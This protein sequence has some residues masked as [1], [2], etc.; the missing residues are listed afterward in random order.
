MVNGELE[1][2]LK[3]LAPTTRG[4]RMELDRAAVPALDG[5]LSAFTSRGPA[6]DGGLK[7][8]LSAP[9]DGVFTAA[10]GQGTRGLRLSGTSLAAPHAAGAAALVWHAARE[11]GWQLSARDVAALLVTGADPAAVRQSAARPETPPITRTG[12][13]ALDVLAAASSRTVVRAGPLASLGLG[14]RALVEALT[15]ERAVTVTNLDSVLRTYQ[16]EAEHRLPGADAGGLKVTAAPA[17]LEL[18][19][20]ETAEVRVRF[21][22]RPESLPEWPMAGGRHVGDGDALTEAE[23]GGWLVVRDDTSAAAPVTQRVPFHLLARRASSV[24]ATWEPG[25]E[26]PEPVQLTNASAHPGTAEAF[27]LGTVDPLHRHLPGPVDLT[28]VGVRA[29]PDGQGNTVLEFLLHAREPYGHPLETFSQ[30]EMDTNMDGVPDYIAYTVDEAGMIAASDRNGRVKVAVEPPGGSPFGTPT[31]RFYAGCDLFSRWLILPLLA[32][33]TGLTPSRLAFQYRVTRRS[34]VDRAAD[35]RWAVDQA[36]G[37]GGWLSFDAR[38]ALPWPAPATARVDGM[39]TAQIE[40][41]GSASLDADLLVLFPDNPPGA[42]DAVILWRQ[43]PPERAFV[44]YAHGGG[45]AR[46]R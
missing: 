40:T 12:S 30:V 33:D 45:Y 4:L 14:H 31:A 18:A 27:V 5:A 11:R 42:A 36:P 7:P 17:A 9:G 21:H 32:E 26:Q 6:R 43:P 25:R 10:L 29:L 22:V 37:D 24:A 28:A 19:P 1:T 20:G 38:T 23:L 41:T 3:E 34:T 46:R 35:G 13:G 8:D 16:L 15:L 2:T 39:G 44:P